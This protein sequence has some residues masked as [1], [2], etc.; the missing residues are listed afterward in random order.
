MILQECPEIQK[1][2][3]ATWAQNDAKRDNN[4]TDDNVEAAT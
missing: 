4:I 2:S 3:G 1:G